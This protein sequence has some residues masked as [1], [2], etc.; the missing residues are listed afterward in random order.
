MTPHELVVDS[1]ARR[2]ALLRYAQ[3]HARFTALEVRLAY[4]GQPIAAFGARIH[5]SLLERAWLAERDDPQPVGLLE[6]S[7]S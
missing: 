6:E 3:A 4:S 7:A 1:R 2:G 5:A